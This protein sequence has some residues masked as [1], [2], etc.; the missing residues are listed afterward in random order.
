MPR[1]RPLPIDAQGAFCLDWLVLTICLVLT[2]LAVIAHGPPRILDATARVAECGGL[3]SC[4]L[5]R[6]ALD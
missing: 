5:V 3:H 1:P 2:S 4:E 6:A